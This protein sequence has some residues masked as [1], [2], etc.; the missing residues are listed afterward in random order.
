MRTNLKLK[1]LLLMLLFQLAVAAAQGFGAEDGLSRG[2]AALKTNQYDKAIEA[3]TRALGTGDNRVEI[4]NNRGIAWTQK[5]DYPQAMA[6]YD[7]A[8]EINP[9]CAETFNN[10]GVVWF[11]KGEYDRSI[12]DYDRALQLDPG[13]YKAYGN[14][15]AAWFYKGN[16]ARAV[17]DYHKALELNPESVEIR[18]QLSRI[19]SFYEAELNGQRTTIPSQPPAGADADENTEFLLKKMPEEVEGEGAKTIQTEVPPKNGGAYCVQV[20]AFQS[21]ENAEAL[22]DRLKDKGYDAQLVPLLSWKEQWWH[23][24]RVGAY[25]SRQEAQI[26]AQDLLEKEGIKPIIRPVGKW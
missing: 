13:F 12:R 23:T 8:L 14:R 22:T 1:T 26:K 11:K 25:G 24:V 7:R 18:E 6:D 2:L 19:E 10:R 15:G 5:G 9:N 21:K 4:Y 20:G 16:R 17:S 3:F